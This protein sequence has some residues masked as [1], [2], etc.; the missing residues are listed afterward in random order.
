VKNFV[1]WCLNFMGGGSQPFGGGLLH[2]RMPWAELDCA[3]GGFCLF[4]GFWLIGLGF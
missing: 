2:L 4:F 3:N 1:G